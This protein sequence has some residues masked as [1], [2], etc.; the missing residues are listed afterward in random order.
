M[1]D[2]ELQLENGNYTRIINKSLD[3]L[4]KI[5]LLGVEL[6][7]C[8]FVVRKT[9]GYNKT[10]DQISITQFEH[11]VKR[12]RP[13]VVKALKNL[14]LVNILQLVK[15]GSSKSQSSEWKFNKYYKKWT[16]NNPLVKPPEL[17]KY[18]DPTSKEK[19]S[20]LVKI[21]KHTK[22]NTKNNIQ[23]KVAQAPTP[24]LITKYFFK[25]VHDLKEKV[26]SKEAV[27][28]RR[29]LQELETKY[30]EADKSTIWKEI[31]K[32][33]D[34]WTELNG[35]GTKQKWQTEKTFQVERRL[36]TWFG[37]I[38]TFTSLPIKNSTEVVQ[39]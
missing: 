36:V 16:F 14:Q 7:I 37:R 19:L 31:K 21:P 34:Y 29:F 27:H 17:V 24:S 5:P 38:E 26:E 33:H 35:S 39:L 12:S 10:S 3:E 11:G 32:F 25:G 18:N 23:K 1:E 4:V 9:W 13:T 30:P 22:N 2:K 6:A 28:T 15:V 8:L 20:Q